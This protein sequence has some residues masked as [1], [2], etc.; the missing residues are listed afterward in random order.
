MVAEPG[1]TGCL[2]CSA[3][4]R[5]RRDSFAEN[6]ESPSRIVLI[7]CDYV[8]R[9]PSLLQHAAMPVRWAISRLPTQAENFQLKCDLFNGNAALFAVEYRVS[10]KVGRTFVP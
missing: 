10:V 6:R 5:H 3:R 2:G 9:V 7:I 8:P 1:I 4:P